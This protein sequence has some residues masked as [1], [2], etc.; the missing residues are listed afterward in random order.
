MTA[1]TLEPSQ[2]NFI[3]REDFLRF[4][5]KHAE[6]AVRVTAQLGEN[7]RTTFEQVRLLGLSHTAA[8]QL[9]RQLVD[10]AGRNGRPSAVPQTLSW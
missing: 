4:I 10:Y 7:Y 2:A 6:V 9:A 5:S 3:R 8:G 1:E